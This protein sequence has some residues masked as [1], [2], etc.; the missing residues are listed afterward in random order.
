MNVFDYLFSYDGRIGRLS[1]LG[2]TIVL[3]AVQGLITAAVDPVLESGSAIGIGGLVVGA[4]LAF[5]ANL[6]LQVKRLHDR[7]QSG[8]R[9]VVSVIPLIGWIYLLVVLF[10]LRGSDGANR[11]GE[12]ESGGLFAGGFAADPGGE[13]AWSSRLAERVAPPAE[14]A[15]TVL[16]KPAVDRRPSGPRGFGR[17]GQA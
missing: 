6:C 14:P 15:P 16:R 2:G 17:R 11:Y 10:L 3:A 13:E 4:I 5:W 8:W 12:P 7:D 9:L 1:F